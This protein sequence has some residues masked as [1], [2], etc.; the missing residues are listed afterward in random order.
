[1][2]DARQ[3]D[4][5]DTNSIHMAQ[6]GAWK[7]TNYSLNDNQGGTY[8]PSTGKWTYP[9]DIQIYS[10][11]V[12]ISNATV[13]YSF[14][15]LFLGEQTVVVK[16]GTEVRPD[17]LWSPSPLDLVGQLQTNLNNA[18]NRV[19]IVEDK[20]TK[21]T[22][23]LSQIINNLTINGVWDPNA[24]PSQGDINGAL[25][26]QYGIAAGNINIFGGT[27]DGSNWI[28]TNNGK[29]DKDITARIN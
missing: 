5:K 28:R 7:R 11:S 20:V 3:T 22:N 24:T 16:N 15:D 2:L 9:N 13:P 4:V 14:G 12:F 27:A 17:G 29:S 6:E 19:K 8:D 21:L 10:A 25:K 26:P 23:A 18:E 1:M